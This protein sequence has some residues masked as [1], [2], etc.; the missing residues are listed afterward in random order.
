MPY[1]APVVTLLLSGDALITRPYYT[2][3]PQRRAF[4]DLLQRTDVRFT[5]LETPLN[6]YIGTPAAN[7]GIHLSAPP[8]A[9]RTLLA[10]GFNLF[11]AANNHALDY[12]IEGLRH[13]MA[14]MR[15]LGM[16]Y[17]GVGET[18]SDA[19]RPAYLDLP[20]ARVALVACTASFGAGAPASASDSGPAVRPGFNPQ[21][22]TTVYTL[23]ATR[24]AQLRDIAEVS[25]LTRHEEWMVNMGY[26]LPLDEPEHQL[27]LFG[28][29]VEQGTSNIR[30]SFPHAG[31]LNRNITS[32]QEAW[33][34]ADLVIVSIH[35]HEWDQVP[36]EPAAFIIDFA[37]A[38]IDAGA[39]IVTG[40]GP[41][42]MRGMEVY[43]RKPIFYS[44]GDLWFEYETLQHL[45]PDAFEQYGLPRTASPA[46]F[47][48]QAM[49]GFHHDPRF[50]E[51]VLPC[52]T[53]QNGELIEVT[54]HPVTLGYGL[55]RTQRGQP[56]LASTEE[57]ER[58]LSYVDA[59][60]RPFGTRIE[61]TKE[62][63]YLRR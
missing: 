40:S 19:A 28:G 14:T 32:V 25:G 42:I 4:V 34:Q 50:W 44:L 15:Q 41:H 51:C 26:Q 35:A 39:D 59:L 31:D 53:F 48:D 3:H 18:L 46:D 27:R 11:A 63:G 62:G 12:G 17:A 45:P 60:S 16:T 23:D 52:C 5:N 8:Q 6:N 54:L 22:A 20:H 10:T 49:Q 1:Q 58:I 13:H 29:V 24:F 33:R 30:R 57:G 37:H 21:R 43:R 61:M 2:N 47:A 36:E 9:G 55:P 56:Q 7:I 38:C